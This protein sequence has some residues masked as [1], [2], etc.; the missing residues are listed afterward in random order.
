M[1]NSAL[2]I[3][4]GV[5][6]SIVLSVILLLIFSVILTYTDLKEETISPVI[7]SI[8]GISLFIGSI[9]ANIKL[10]KNGIFNGACIGIIYLFLIYI[11]SSIVNGNFMINFKSIIMFVVAIICGILGGIIGVN[12][13]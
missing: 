11:I 4:K 6:I 9:I 8:T 13:K 10:N 3:L 2:N 5:I 1:Q 7:I 12:K